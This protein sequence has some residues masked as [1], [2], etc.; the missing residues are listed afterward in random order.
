MVLDISKLQHELENKIKENNNLQNTISGLKTDFE[1]TKQMNSELNNKK[2]KII[3]SLE[4]GINELEQAKQ[5]VKDL[6]KE[7]YSLL[8]ELKEI[9]EFH[10]KILS[11]YKAISEKY[12]SSEKKVAELESLKI[13]L[14][15]KA[16][17]NKSLHEGNII[18]ITYSR[19]SS[20]ERR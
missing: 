12:N 4:K 20:N 5:R 11:D 2:E 13:E 1:L 6:E 14:G 8:D 18:F 19:N 16:D 10:E 9:R 3:E 15:R 7:K 17:E